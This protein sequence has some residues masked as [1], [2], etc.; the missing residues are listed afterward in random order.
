MYSNCPPTAADPPAAGPFG[1]VPDTWLP[2]LMV[3]TVVSASTHTSW[4]ADDTSGPGDRWFTLAPF[5]MVAVEVLFS[6]NTL[7]PPPI[8]TEPPDSPTSA[9]PVPLTNVVPRAFVLPN[10]MP[11]T[12][13]RTV[14]DM[15]ARN[16]S[17]VAWP[18]W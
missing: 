15:Y 14:L 8:P 10:R 13:G 4:S 18:I 16:P 17:A 12:I 9:S 6:R 7:I 2:R 5:P 11:V 3:M 1:L